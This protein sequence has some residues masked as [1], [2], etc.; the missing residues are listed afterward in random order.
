M[1]ERLITM[2]KRITGMPDYAG[3]VKHLRSCHPERPV[4]GEREF[5]EDYLGRRY[6]NESSRCC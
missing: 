6:G 4:P 2:I 5:F 1:I 3:Y